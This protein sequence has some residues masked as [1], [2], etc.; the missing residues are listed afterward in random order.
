[1]NIN[2]YDNSFSDK[3]PN[4]NN[5]MPEENIENETTN[6][7]VFDFDQEDIEFLKKNCTTSKIYSPSEYIENYAELKEIKTEDGEEILED[8][9]LE[10][11]L[12]DK[13][14][15]EDVAYINASIYL[16]QKGIINSKAISNYETDSNFNKDTTFN[17]NYKNDILTYAQV[18]IANTDRST[19]ASEL[20]DTYI[21]VVED[22]ASGIESCEIG[23]AFQ[24]EDEDYIRIKTSEDSSE[25]MSISKDT[26]NKLFPLIERF[27]TK[28]GST[29]DCYLIESLM[30]IYENPSERA[31][32]VSMFSEDEDGNITVT[33][34]GSSVSVVFENGELPES[35]DY[36]DYSIGAD[37]YKLL[38]YTYGTAVKE[39][40]INQVMDELSTDELVDFTEFL[41]EHG[42]DTFV[43]K[44]KDGN[45]TYTTFEEAKNTGLLS[46]YNA[47]FK[48][49][50]NAS[51]TE[52]YNS[53]I[54]GN[55]GIAPNVLSKLGYNVETI[56]DKD[57]MIE[58]L[59]TP[60]FL[61]D[62]IVFIGAYNHQY[63]LS[64]NTDSDGNTTYYINNPYGQANPI[65]C[66]FDE[67]IEIIE[68]EP[69][70]D[71]DIANR[72]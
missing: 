5:N 3:K 4:S 32:L 63:S 48:Y 69:I 9:Q 19:L 42:T 61:E 59:K 70:V 29:G 25:L 7:N 43:S 55:G 62:N 46:E 35:E 23:D 40:A 52:S 36:E 33:L 8:E 58:R 34:P 71:M 72:E 15:S 30:R 47:Y 54:I 50:E 44:D 68:T 13:I 11:I 24:V 65:E 28:Q 51:E 1:M 53:Y 17:E 49:S 60:G 67:L 14:D 41:E 27:A 18:E 45:I 38:E 10:R 6:Q 66:T 22:E 31:Y 21:P 37:G 12:G 20:E 56:K 39:D 57:E 64:S 26:Y 2:P 16:I